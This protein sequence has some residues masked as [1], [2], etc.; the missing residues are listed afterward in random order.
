MRAYTVAATAVTLGV[1]KKWVDNVLSHHRVPGVLQE[2]QGIVRRVTPAGLLTLEIAASLV[3]A[4]NLPI[5]Q[6]LET[7]VRLIA[8]RG[9]EIQLRAALSIQI[10]ADVETI[11][12]ELNTRLEKAIE[13]SPTP[14]RGRPRRK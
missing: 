11:T 14:R 3:R 10:S 6:A 4:L 9:T 7:A 8:A 5:A 2:R 13:I 1:T 12:H